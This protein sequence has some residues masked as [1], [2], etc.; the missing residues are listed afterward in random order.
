[1][2][3]TFDFD[4]KNEKLNASLKNI[5]IQELSSML[6][7]SKIFDSKANLNL[8]YD[9]LVKKGNLVGKLTNG[10]LLENGFVSLSWPVSKSWF[11]KRAFMK[12]LILIHKLMIEF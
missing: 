4:L 9:L 2:G 12:Q 11:N 6:D 7:Y 5:E 3:G 8:D 10:H 1:M